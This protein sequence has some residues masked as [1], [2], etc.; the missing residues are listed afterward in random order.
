MCKSHFR[1]PNFDKNNST[2]KE[3]GNEKLPQPATARTSTDP[4]T[5]SKRGVVR[6]PRRR[7]AG[8]K[9]H[10]RHLYISANKCLRYLT[11]NRY[12]VS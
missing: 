1:K 8:T 10:D 4:P 2:S 3:K 5:L 6:R 9:I 12:T 11:N 7:S